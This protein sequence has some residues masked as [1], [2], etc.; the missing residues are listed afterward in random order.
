MRLLLAI[1]IL[2]TA[3]AA[4]LGVAD[5]ADAIKDPAQYPISALIA[6]NRARL[7]FLLTVVGALPGLVVAGLETYRRRVDRKGLVRKYLQQIH[8]RSFRH[9][10]GG[11]AADHRVSL[12]T[13]NKRR[14]SRWKFWEKKVR[15]MACQHR[16]DG[17]SPGRDWEIE[18]RV[19]LVVRAFH[20]QANLIV[21]PP[22]EDDPIDLKRYLDES[23]MSAEDR[24]QRSWPNAGMYAVPLPSNEAE[25]LAVLL[26]EAKGL[27]VA[28]SELEWDAKTLTLLLGAK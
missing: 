24:A 1:G 7:V 6:R 15:V 27:D 22:K 5:F 17:T 19:G 28:C 3:L 25:P 4:M 10:E 21:S 23:N 26:V 16:T 13:V 12:F 20:Y 18:K 2:A 8:L 11:M 9:I 14:P